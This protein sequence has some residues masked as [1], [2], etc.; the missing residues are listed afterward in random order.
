[1]R[2]RLERAQLTQTRCPADRCGVAYLHHHTPIELG[3]YLALADLAFKSL[4]LS[5]KSMNL[6]YDEQTALSSPAHPHLSESAQ[7]SRY[8]QS[9][10]QQE[11]AFGLQGGGRCVYVLKAFKDQAH[12]EIVRPQLSELS[13]VL[14]QPQGLTSQRYW[15]EQQ[16]MQGAQG[17]QSAV[18]MIIDSEGETR[19]EG[20]SLQQ[21]MLCHLPQGFRSLSERE[22]LSFWVQRTGSDELRV[23]VS[24]ALLTLEPTSP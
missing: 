19:D 14:Y 13:S 12:E 15:L 1:M 7:H 6:A 24:G 8:E 22:D 11:V 4:K 16:R 9:V 18:L 21:H 10:S 17:E 2:E 23:E 3:Y 5:L 20:L